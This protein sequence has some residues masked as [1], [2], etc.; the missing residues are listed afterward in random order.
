[1]EILC[2]DRCHHGIVRVLLAIGVVIPKP[3]Y[4]I[5][6]EEIAIGILM[7]WRRTRNEVVGCGID[8]Q[9]I[10]KFRTAFIT[11]HL[12]NDSREIASRAITTNRDTC[13]VAGNAC[14]VLRNPHRCCI[15]VL[16]C[17]RKFVFRSKPIINRNDDTLSRI[18]QRTTHAVIAIECTNRP[19]TAMKKD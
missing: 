10:H 5:T 12:W 4:R 6:R 18:C 17:R 14:R 1:M 15:S 9:L 16:N 19:A 7:H 11:C 3:D 13:G 2:V 8:Q